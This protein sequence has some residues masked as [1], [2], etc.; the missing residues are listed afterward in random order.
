[1]AR[2]RQLLVPE[3]R[4]GLERLKATVISR[5]LGRNIPAEEV[6]YEV[7][8]QIGVPLSPGYNGELK[9]KNTGK[10]GGEIGGQMVKELVRIAQEKLSEKAGNSPVGYERVRNDTNSDAGAEENGKYHRRSG[11]S[12]RSCGKH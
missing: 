11:D 7:A 4:K 10:V 2:K 9:T 3:S 12:S 1:M 8:Q 5:K 6:K